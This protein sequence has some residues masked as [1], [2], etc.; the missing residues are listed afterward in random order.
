M[1][2]LVRSRSASRAATFPR[3]LAWRISRFDRRRIRPS[4]SRRSSSH[5]FHRLE[6]RGPRINLLERD[7]SAGR[8]GHD[9][10][11][12][13]GRARRG[14]RHIA[15]AAAT[16]VRRP[17]SA[18]F[19]GQ[20]AAIHEC[21]GR[22]RRDAICRLPCRRIA[23]AWRLASRRRESDDYGGPRRE[24]CHHRKRARVPPY[25]PRGRVGARRARYEPGDARHLRLVRAGR[26]GDCAALVRGRPRRKDRH[27]AAASATAV[28]QD[29]KSHEQTLGFR[30]TPEITLRVSHR[31]REPFGRTTW[32]HLGAVSVV[33][34]R[35]WM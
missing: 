10:G 24:P 22:R 1:N 21:R 14:D 30:L 2:G 5:R 19:R 31:M 9:V 15:V 18:Q 34:Y 13:L 35:R 29:F 25:E 3:P 8:A 11:D 16:R 27:D 6:F 23:D 17:E 4:P 26:A 20:S 12:A 32:D 28:E 33:W 7:L